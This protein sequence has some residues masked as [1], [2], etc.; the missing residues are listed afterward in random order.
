MYN[1]SVI[2]GEGIIFSLSAIEDE[3]SAENH[4]A[5]AFFASALL[6]RKNCSRA[7]YNPTFGGIN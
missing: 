2:N 7:I 6:T 4:I 5:K 3:A 1:L